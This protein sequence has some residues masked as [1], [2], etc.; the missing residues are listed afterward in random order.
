MHVLVRSFPL[1]L[2]LVACG[3]PAQDAPV[4]GDTSAVATDQPR[5]VVMGSDTLIG[6]E[7]LRCADGRLLSVGYFKG[8]TE[9]AAVN[10]VGDSAVWARSTAADTGVRYATLDESMILWTKGD[11]ASL[12]WQG[13]ITK[14]VVDTTIEF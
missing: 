6:R 8:A 7:S 13:L 2:V 11:T 1:A 3:A 5:P 12:T 4:D 10:I 9:R 14:C